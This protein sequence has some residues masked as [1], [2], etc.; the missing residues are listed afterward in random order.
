VGTAENSL[1]KLSRPHWLKSLAI[2]RRQGFLSL[3]RRIVFALQQMLL[4]TLLKGQ[5]HFL[6]LLCNGAAGMNGWG[7]A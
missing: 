5:W 1:A 6:R 4:T 2:L 3:T 7:R